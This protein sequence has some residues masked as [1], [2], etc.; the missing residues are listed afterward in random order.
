MEL[1]KNIVQ[2]GKPD[3]VHKIFVEDY[4]V[5]YIKQLNR[6]CEDKS[7][8]LALYGKM[9][10]EEGCKYYF[11]YGAAKIEGLQHRAAYL[12]QMEKE[13]IAEVGNQY[14]EEYEFLAWCSLKGEPV[15]KLFVLVQGK[16]VEVEGYACFYEKNECML[17]Y[18]LVAGQAA[19]EK[20][21]ATREEV[22]SQEDGGRRSARGEWK[23]SDY[24]PAVSKEDKLNASLD[25]KEREHIKSDKA[26]KNAIA[27]KTDYMKMAAVG[28]FLVLC[29]IGITTMEDSGKMEDLQ[30]VANQVITNITEQKLPD[31][32]EVIISGGNAEET[33]TPKPQTET[34]LK[35]PEEKVLSQTVEVVYPTPE[36]TSE[37]AQEEGL[38][39][40]REEEL[41]EQ[42]VTAVQEYSSY[43]IA[44]GDT[45]I[46]ICMN[47][48]GS[49]ERLEEICELNG[50][51]NADNI[52]VGQ[53][54]LLP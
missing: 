28:L 47:R 51:S 38:E 43:T 9:F 48:Y 12:S 27:K 19:E 32:A 1:P 3:K 5:S 45:L 46:Y 42:T 15:E 21:S 16:G 13:E 44:K 2:I 14:F 10:E 41:E 31:E 18:M 11:L 17:N 49:L 25:N 35:V 52:Q 37:V 50:I 29:V 8:G 53:T 39:V 20:T 54:I 26:Q 34:E 4:V 7:A 40:T 30:V 6:S 24:M 36:A 23:A 33:V 22:K